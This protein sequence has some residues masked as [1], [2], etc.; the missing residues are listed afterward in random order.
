MGIRYAVAYGV[1]ED[2]A[3]MIPLGGSYKEIFIHRYMLFHLGHLS[4]TTSYALGVL[5]LLVSLLIY[6]S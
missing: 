2:E 1:M 6:V 5:F 4:K 3:S